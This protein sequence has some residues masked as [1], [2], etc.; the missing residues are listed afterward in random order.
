MTHQESW[1][2]LLGIHEATKCMIEIA[3]DNPDRSGALCSACLDL[4][5]LQGALIPEEDDYVRGI[6]QVPTTA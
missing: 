1:L 6:T 4:L 3:R 2:L 5:E